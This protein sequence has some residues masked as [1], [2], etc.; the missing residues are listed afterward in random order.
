MLE[1]ELGLAAD[2]EVGAPGSFVVLVDGEPVVQK[3]SMAF[4]TEDE[5]VAAV[6]ARVGPRG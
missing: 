1:K 2:L 4:P 3:R 6:R 5:I